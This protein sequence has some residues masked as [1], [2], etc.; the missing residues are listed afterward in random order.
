MPETDLKVISLPDEQSM[1]SR[2]T[3]VFDDAHA[4]ANFYPL[5]YKSAGREVNG[6]GVVMVVQLAIADYVQTLPPPMPAIMQFWLRPIVEALI[7]DDDVKADA[8]H[9]IDE[10]ETKQRLDI[11]PTPPG[12]PEL[13]DDDKESLMRHIKHLAEVYDENV[14]DKYNSSA[15]YRAGGANPFYDQTLNGLYLEF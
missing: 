6:M 1:F 3:A 5:L 14:D 13:S 2:L 7:D 12:R 8:V 11:H 10:A 15:A 9:F 4:R